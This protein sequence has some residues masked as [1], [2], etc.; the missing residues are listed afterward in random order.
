MLET[1]FSKSQEKPSP[2]TT[3]SGSWLLI[4]KTIGFSDTKY[5]F[6]IYNL[7]YVET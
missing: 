1:S 6:I 5:F 7:I 2:K 4:M 3:K